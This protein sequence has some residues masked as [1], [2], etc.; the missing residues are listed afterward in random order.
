MRTAGGMVCGLCVDSTQDSSRRSR[1]VQA[2]DSC[3]TGGKR[4]E[5][6]EQ[7]VWQLLAPPQLPPDHDAQHADAVFSD[8][9][10]TI[11][12]GL[13][14]GGGE[15]L[16]YLEDELEGSPI[17]RD[18]ARTNSE[19]AAAGGLDEPPPRALSL[20]IGSPFDTLAIARIRWVVLGE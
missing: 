16:E 19:G 3:S 20:R 17:D 11:P 12:A 13:L 14:E 4:A 7:S 6:Q 8:H 15:L 18:G 10:T 9:I 5:V 1:G 2:V